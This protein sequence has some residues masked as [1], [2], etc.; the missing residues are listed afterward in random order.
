MA[1]RTVT[2]PIY[3]RE[4][5]EE[6]D[7]EPLIRSVQ[8]YPTGRDQIQASSAPPSFPPNNPPPQKKILFTPATLISS[9]RPQYVYTQIVAAPGGYSVGIRYLCVDEEVTVGAA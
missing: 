5:G 1:A 9:T 7:E 3:V 2:I 4:W 6:E 8:H